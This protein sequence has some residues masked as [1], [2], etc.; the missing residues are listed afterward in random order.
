MHAVTPGTP[1]RIRS[2]FVLYAYAPQC[3]AALVP[4]NGKDH[5]IAAPIKGHILNQAARGVGHA[6]VGRLRPFPVF[7]LL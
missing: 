5:A 1:K 4:A 7:C 2:W 3:N 6:K